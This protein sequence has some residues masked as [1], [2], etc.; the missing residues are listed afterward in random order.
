MRVQL[1][2]VPADQ[3]AWVNGGEGSASSNGTSTSGNVLA[4]RHDTSK[5][6][7]GNIR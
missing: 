6:A 5:N 7:I 2:R 4:T 1:P 3:L